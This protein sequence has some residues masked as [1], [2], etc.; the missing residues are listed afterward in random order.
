AEYRPGAQFNG[1]GFGPIPGVERSGAI[2]A[3]NSATGE[4]KWEFPLHSGAWAGVL[5]TACNLVFGSSNEGDFYAL[6]ATAGRLLWRF[7]TG[8]RIN[9]NPITYL[10]GGKQHVAIA[11]GNS[12]FAFA[13]ES[14]ET[15]NIYTTCGGCRL[16]PSHSDPV[17]SRQLRALR[18]SAQIP[19]PLRF[20]DRF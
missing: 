4:L 17:P 3:L 15:R 10:S 16:L 8:A 13:P 12:I 20:T 9:A 6:D 5:S 11:S 1:G 7:Q 2:R 18:G 14:V 19:P